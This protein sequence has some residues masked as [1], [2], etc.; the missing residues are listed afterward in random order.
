[1]FVTA[2]M[3]PRLT[4]RTFECLVENK[5][6]VQDVSY[7]GWTG[8]GVIIPL[9]PPIAHRHL[10]RF[11]FMLACVQ[12]QGVSNPVIICMYTETK[13]ITFRCTRLSTATQDSAGVPPLIA[14]KT[15]TAVAGVCLLGMKRAP[16]VVHFHTYMRP[17][18]RVR[19]YRSI[20]QANTRPVVSR[21]IR[22]FVTGLAVL[23]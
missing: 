9:P 12:F 22:S 10:P 6:G 17:R 1:M 4:R 18:R 2:E 21:A 14:P 23:Q 3:R 19:M 5:T 15:T 11:S 13:E 7:S 16:G 8:R 20:L